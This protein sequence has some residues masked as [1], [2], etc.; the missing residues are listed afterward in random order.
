MGKGSKPT[1]SGKVRCMQC[2]GY[3]HTRIKTCERCRGAGYKLVGQS[4]E[5]CNPCNGSGKVPIDR[6]NINAGA[7]FPGATP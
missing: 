1:R 6:I 5:P 7:R 3:G 2:C 4:N